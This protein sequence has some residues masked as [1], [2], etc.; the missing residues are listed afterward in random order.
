MLP[1]VYSFRLTYL[2]QL[3]VV[4]KGAGARSQRRLTARS[5][6]RAIQGV[7]FLDS[8]NRKLSLDGTMSLPIDMPAE[9]RNCVSVLDS[10]TYMRRMRGYLFCLAELQ[11]LRLPCSE[12]TLADAVGFDA[13]AAPTSHV[14]S[15]AGPLV[16]TWLHD[17]GHDSA[18]CELSRDV[19][20]TAR[21]T[22]CRLWGHL[23][24]H[25][26]QRGYTA[27]VMHTAVAV[28]TYGIFPSLLRDSYVSSEVTETLLAVATDVA[29]RT[30]QVQGRLII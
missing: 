24:T 27:A 10:D 8:A 4:G 6:F 1:N 23:W 12:E 9:T 21:C 28:R 5:K 17:E 13:E 2:S 3:L 18:V 20:I 25:M 15:N 19:L 16:N 26:L 14:Q 22:D 7:L 11:E 30:E 29:E